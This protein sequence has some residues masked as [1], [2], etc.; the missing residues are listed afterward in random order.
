MI[1]KKDVYITLTTEPTLLTGLHAR[2]FFKVVSKLFPVRSGN[3]ELSVISE[4]AW[5]DF[6]LQVSSES[7]L[8]NE[9]NGHIQA[10]YSK[11]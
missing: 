5:F 10:F 8:E 3:L 7:D 6:T 1:Q 11:N 2:G 4:I 9:I